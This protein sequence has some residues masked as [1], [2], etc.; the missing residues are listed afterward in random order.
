MVRRADFR[1]LL[2]GK[3]YRKVQHISSFWVHQ[4]KGWINVFNQDTDM[5]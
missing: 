1:G 4:G 5:K 3:E 2:V